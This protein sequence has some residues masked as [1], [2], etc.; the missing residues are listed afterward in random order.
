MNRAVTTAERNWR[1]ETGAN[2]GL[3]HDISLRYRFAVMSVDPV[4]PALPRRI[5]RNARR[6]SLQA[7]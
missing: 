6:H 7:R 4:R 5:P 3:R 2:L 1:L